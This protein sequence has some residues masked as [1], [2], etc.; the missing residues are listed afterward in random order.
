MFGDQSTSEESLVLIC[1]RGGVVVGKS[2][3][4]DLIIC[5]VCEEEDM[6]Q[7]R[8]K[9]VTHSIFPGQSVSELV[10]RDGELMT[11]FWFDLI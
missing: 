11:D 1:V 5:F 10:G 8:R 3:S 4:E 2:V 9:K 7:H 6:K